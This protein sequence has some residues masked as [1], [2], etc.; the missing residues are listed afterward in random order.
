VTASQ[1]QQAYV[2]TL[3]RLVDGRHEYVALVVGPLSHGLGAG[4]RSPC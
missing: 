4:W 3:E 2:V 1:T